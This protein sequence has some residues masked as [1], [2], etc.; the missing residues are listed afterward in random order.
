[1]VSEGGTHTPAASTADRG[2]SPRV[3]LLS[4]AWLGGKR[5]GLL[6]RDGASFDLAL[7]IRDGG[8]PLGEVMSFVSGLYFRGKLAY[9]RA[10]A[11]APP[12]AAGALVILPQGGLAPVDVPVT[13][14][15]LEQ[16]GTG[17][18]EV[19]DP[20]FRD[21]LLAAA[22]LV[23]QRLEPGGR[24]VLLGSIAT[25]RYCAPLLEALG[26][27]L[28]FPAA[29]VGR[30]DNSRGG[31]MLRAARSGDELDYIPVAG[32]TRKGPRPPRLPRL[33]RRQEQAG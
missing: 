12:G 5:A 20:V 33:P 19:S 7:R 22:R 32:A 6:L 31:L 3:F 25:D 2:R 24:A 8:A 30:G 4:P 11:A 10:F 28:H 17:D 18:I 9:A 27:R 23:A 29:F 16:Q 14:R 15:E 21:G 13:R 1:M 26:D